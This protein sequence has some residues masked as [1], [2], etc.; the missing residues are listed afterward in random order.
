MEEE[1]KDEQLTQEEMPDEEAEALQPENI[2]IPRPKWQVVGA[3]IALVLFL[4]VIAG[5]YLNIARGG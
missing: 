4:L 5:F 1:R 2:Y 3:W